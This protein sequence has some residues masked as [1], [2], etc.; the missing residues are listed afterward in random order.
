MVSICLALVIQATKARLVY[1]K[2]K[3]EMTCQEYLTL[4]SHV[5]G[6]EHEKSLTDIHVLLCYSDNPTIIF[7]RRNRTSFICHRG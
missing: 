1:E 2:N 4:K 7:F 3:N 6:K 5:R